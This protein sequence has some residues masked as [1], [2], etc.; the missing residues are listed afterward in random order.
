MVFKRIKDNI[1]GDFTDER[2]KR[3][4][5]EAEQAAMEQHP[6]VSAKAGPHC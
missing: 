3:Q 4:E 2:L 1:I 5:Y 6:P